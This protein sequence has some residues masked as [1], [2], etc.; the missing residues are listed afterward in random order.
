MMKSPKKKL[1]TTDLELKK[2]KEN[3]SQK[4]KLP[5]KL[6]L[7]ITTMME[8]EPNPLEKDQNKREF[9]LNLTHKTNTLDPV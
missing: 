5:K 6:N 2:E 4:K 3:Q 7:I 8:R 1:L 9:L